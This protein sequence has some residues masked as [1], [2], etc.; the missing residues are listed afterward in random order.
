MGETLGTAS[1]RAGDKENLGGG[2]G[3]TTQIQ[4]QS[5]QTPARVT[6]SGSGETQAGFPPPHPAVRPGGPRA[7]DLA[8]PTEGTRKTNYPK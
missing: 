6:P 2:W 7:E 5:L 8:A 1:V 4:I 3:A